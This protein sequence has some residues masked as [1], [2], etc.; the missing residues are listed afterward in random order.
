MT[1]GLRLRAFLA[2]ALRSRMADEDG[3][4]FTK[5]YAL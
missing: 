1:A 2:A 4:F 3:P 5:V